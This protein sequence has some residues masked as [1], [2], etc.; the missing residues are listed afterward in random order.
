[1]A[2][3]DGPEL[4][5]QELFER[6]WLLWGQR[7]HHLSSDPLSHETELLSAAAL[8]RFLESSPDSLLARQRPKVELVLNV[9]DALRGRI[10]PARVPPPPSPPPPPPPPPNSFPGPDMPPE[11]FT[12]M[13]ECVEIDESE[14]EAD[15]VVAAA[16]LSDECPP[17]PSLAQA[18]SPSAAPKGP[19]APRAAPIPAAEPWAGRCLC[20]A[21]MSGFT[22]Y[23][24]PHRLPHQA[25]SGAP[26]SRRGGQRSLLGG[27]EQFCRAF[28]HAN[29]WEA[30]VRLCLACAVDLKGLALE[31]PEARAGHS[32]GGKNAL[33]AGRGGGARGRDEGACSK[34]Q[35]TVVARLQSAVGDDVYVARYANCFRGASERNVHA[36]EFFMSDAAALEALR[37]GAVA[38]CRLYMSY[39]PCHHSGG[40]L[41][42]DRHR[43]LQLASRRANQGHPTSCTERL[44]SF[45]EAEMRGRG[46]ALDLVVAD[47]YKVCSAR[48]GACA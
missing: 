33:R 20:A 10:Q 18:P 31:L 41:P 15:A 34:A 19:M 8:F 9:I 28:Y 4:V 22:T 42:D 11:S 24:P 6:V 36:E 39:Q 3:L 48:V 35:V 27:L 38:R 16:S 47:L 29:Q 45:V 17:S 37:S 43:Q 46:I 26:Q 2:I 13:T 14:G 7:V 44:L 40:R 23:P 25:G 32:G 5:P 1:M 12:H 21:R 30:G